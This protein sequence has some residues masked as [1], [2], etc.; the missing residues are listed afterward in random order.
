MD[1]L[2]DASPLHTA[3]VRR[4]LRLDA[5]LSLRPNA[6]S[7]AGQV[8]W[9]FLPTPWVGHRTRYLL[10]QAGSF[11]GRQLLFERFI[12]RTLPGRGLYY[13]EGLDFALTRF[14]AIRSW[15]DLDGL[16][17]RDIHTLC[18]ARQLGLRRASQVREAFPLDSS[19][20]SSELLLV[21]VTEGA[22]RTT[23]E[24]Q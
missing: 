4:A 23:Q 20:H 11:E 7:I 15:E 6:W 19:R 9:F 5:T 3:L 8:A 18:L 1:E 17:R 10:A 14:E 22:I 21:L 24:L 12:S 2:L 16:Q 13:D